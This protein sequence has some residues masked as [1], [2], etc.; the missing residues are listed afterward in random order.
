MHCIVRIDGWTEHGRTDTSEEGMDQW[1]DDWMGMG[2][3]E[4]QPTYGVTSIVGDVGR[5]GGGERK[6]VKK[7]LPAATDRSE[8]PDR[9]KRRKEGRKGRKLGKLYFSHVNERLAGW[10]SS[11]PGSDFS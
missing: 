7:W 8:E 3:R 2:W 10:I 1:M 5:D 11:P 9:Q 6:K 4:P